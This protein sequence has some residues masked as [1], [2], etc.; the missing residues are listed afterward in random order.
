MEIT[1]RAPAFARRLVGPGRAGTSQATSLRAHG[2]IRTCCCTSSVRHARRRDACHRTPS[3]SA[4]L[5]RTTLPGH[6]SIPAGE[7]S[8]PAVRPVACRR[9]SSPPV[10]LRLHKQETKGVMRKRHPRRPRY[11]HKSGE[12]RSQRAVRRRQERRDRRCQA[13]GML[14]AA[15]RMVGSAAG[16]ALA[17]VPQ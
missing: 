3:V 5:P 15:P 17:D 2:Y 6:R 12:R 7:H 9:S 4:T 8:S 10:G 13:P 14:H 11:S 16:V 1:I